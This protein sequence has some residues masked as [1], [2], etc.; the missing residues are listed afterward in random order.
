MDISVLEKGTMVLKHVR[1]CWLSVAYFVLGN[2]AYVLATTHKRR[3]LDNVLALLTMLVDEREFNSQ[4]EGIQA[5]TK[6]GSDSL[7]V[8]S[9]VGRLAGSSCT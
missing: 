7:S 3:R 1:S 4:D 6:I 5:F 9:L 2:F 8:A